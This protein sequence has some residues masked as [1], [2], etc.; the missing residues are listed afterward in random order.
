[1]LEKHRKNRR[2]TKNLLD[3][4]RWAGYAAAGA[5]TL[6]GTHEAAE[7]GIHYSGPVN[8]VVNG[9]TSSR[10]VNA[11]TF[12]IDANGDG[13]V[14]LVFSHQGVLSSTYSAAFGAAFVFGP[15]PPGVGQV[16]GFSVQ[17]PQRTY[18][19]AYNLP[20]GNLINSLPFVS[21]GT[22]AFT[23]GFTYSQFVDSDGYVGFKFESDEGTHFGWVQVDMDASPVNAFTVVDYAW[24]DVGD[25]VFAGEVPEPGSLGLL[26]TGA[27]GLMLWRRKRRG[28]KPAA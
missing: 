15:I 21:G 20:K 22:M 12:P 25:D 19:Y 1:M 26:A 5:A 7:A 18:A 3:R 9:A 10:Y 23:S 4:A 6:M 17:G 28:K 16:A 24:G 27:V 2:G 11:A 8:H 14:D 13:K